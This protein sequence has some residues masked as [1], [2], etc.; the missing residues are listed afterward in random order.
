MNAEAIGMNL[1]V[2]V[3]SSSFCGFPGGVLAHLRSDLG[4]RR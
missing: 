3:E 2:G 4:A 1:S